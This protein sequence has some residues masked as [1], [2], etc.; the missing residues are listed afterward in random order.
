VKR[1]QRRYKKNFRTSDL[2]LHGIKHEDVE[3]MV[4]NYVLLNNPPMSIITGNSDE[5]KRIVE[6]VLEKHDIKFERFKPA[7]M[8]IIK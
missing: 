4:E 3:R 2:D 5:M 7:R 8:T 1:K 6:R